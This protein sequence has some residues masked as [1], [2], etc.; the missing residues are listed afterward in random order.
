MISILQDLMCCMAFLNPNSADL[1]IE[2]PSIRPPFDV[3]DIL[4]H[5]TSTR[6]AKF[7]KKKMGRGNRL[8]W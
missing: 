2:L 1:N 8:V 7:W 5:C 6:S 3:P 4:I